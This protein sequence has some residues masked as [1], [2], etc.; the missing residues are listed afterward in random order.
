MNSCEGSGGRICLRKLLYLSI[1]LH[2]TSY[3]IRCSYCGLGTVC[4]GEICN[5]TYDVL[6]VILCKMYVIL[7]VMYV[8]VCVMYVILCIMYVIL[9]V[10]YVILCC[11]ISLE[12]YLEEGPI[13]L[14]NFTLLVLISWTYASIDTLSSVLT[15]LFS[16]L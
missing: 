2:C 6:Y 5:I 7:C 1:V 10:M 4:L 9:Y 13:T 11:V 8:I 14:I 16:C 3:F 12:R 15:N